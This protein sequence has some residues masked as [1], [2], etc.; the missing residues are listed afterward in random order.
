MAL[1]LVIDD[2]KEI[3]A[4]ICDV[5]HFEGYKVIKAENGTI[6]LQKSKD[7]KPELILC[8]ILMPGIDGFKV[9]EE[10]R[11][12]PATFDIP[13]IFLTVLNK[14]E[15]IVKGLKMGAQDYIKKP[16]DNREVLVRVKIHIELKK[17]RE[18][19]K[20]ISN[21]LYDELYKAENEIAILKLYLEELKSAKEE[22]YRRELFIEKI[23]RH[24][25]SIDGMMNTFKSLKEQSDQN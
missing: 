11:K 5:L 20:T 14:P 24:L 16:Y 1:I 13:F 19:R 17:D 23:E 10:I 8:D 9:L 15:D 2:E 3:L 12:D 18:A 22:L 4:N 21:E 6:G 7:H 25:K